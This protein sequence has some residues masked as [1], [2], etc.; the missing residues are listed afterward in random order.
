[1][2]SVGPYPG[3]IP[4]GDGVIFGEL[5]E[6]PNL[7]LLDTLESNGRVYSRQERFFDGCD[8]K[9]Y[10]AWIYLLPEG[11]PRK[12]VIVD[13]NWEFQHEHLSG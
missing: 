13:G 4:A 7:R 9:R 12:N 3:V 1:M 10:L 2:I 6:V 11:H 5:W 8:G